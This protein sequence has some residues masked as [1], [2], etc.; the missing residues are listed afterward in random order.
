[1][2][3]FILL[4]GLIVS[5]TLI[6]GGCGRLGKKKNLGGP[7]SI[8]I[9]GSDGGYL[10]AEEPQGAKGVLDVRQAAKDGDDVLVMGRVGGSKKPFLDGLAGF[11][12]V[13][14]SLKQCSERLGDNCDTPWDYCCED[15]AELK[16]ATILVKFVDDGGKTLREDARELL[17]LEPLQTVVVR[18][19]AK[20]DADGNLTVLA[21]ALH[22]RG[23]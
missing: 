8:Q 6:A 1:M 7:V 20:R 3:R 10:L 5:V 13:D 16:R 11:T 17:G 22:V 18:G 4:F 14:P 19:K 21:S 12:I 15:P 9:D 2:Q 23:K